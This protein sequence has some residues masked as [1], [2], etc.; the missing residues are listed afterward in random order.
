[1]IIIFLLMTV[2]T[3]LE[4]SLP[5]LGRRTVPF[6]AMPVAVHIDRPLL[7]LWLFHMFFFS[8]IMMLVVRPQMISILPRLNKP[9]ADKKTGLLP[10][11]MVFLF[12]FLRMAVVVSVVRS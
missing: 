5:C 9:F 1:M 6:L 2:A 3:S 10:K 7:L 8:V 11:T 4:R 12:L